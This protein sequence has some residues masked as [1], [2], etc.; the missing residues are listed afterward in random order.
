MKQLKQLLE[1]IFFAQDNRTINISFD[2]SPIENVY[3]TLEKFKAALSAVGIDNTSFQPDTLIASVVTTED[4][5][6][7]LR[8]IVDD[9]GATVI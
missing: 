3:E 6:D 7:E 4:K 5:I 9:F 8:K 1:N 2:K